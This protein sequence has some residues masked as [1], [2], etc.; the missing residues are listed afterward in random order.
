MLMHFYLV[1]SV[2]LCSLL[3]MGGSV[4][5]R[6]DLNMDN[7]GRPT[8]HNTARVPGFNGQP[9]RVALVFGGYYN[10][11]DV[12]VEDVS[13]DRSQCTGDVYINTPEG[14]INLGSS[15]S[16]SRLPS[17]GIASSDDAEV[18][19]VRLDIG[20]LSELFSRY[21]AISV[22]KNGAENGF[23]FLGESTDNDEFENFCVDGSLMSLPYSCSAETGSCAIQGSDFSFDGRTASPPEHRRPAT[24][25]GRS[26]MFTVPLLM[27]QS[28]NEGLI[29][30]GA[31]PFSPFET[32]FNCSI[33]HNW[34]DIL[35][36]IRVS[37]PS[38]Y[39]LLSA[40]D[41]LAFDSVAG[42]CQP[43]LSNEFRLGMFQPVPQIQPLLL[44]GINIR[45]RANASSIDMCDSVL[46]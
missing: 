3:V 43:K 46:Y 2:P 17:I 26:G 22:I 40:S 23:L 42:S 4:Y 36:Q 18:R 21:D 29:S 20:P 16:E 38:G 10:F 19:H 25:V 27:L 5:L 13:F 14:E 33:D 28:I 31:V 8:I 11:V 15:S 1:A 24:M 6:I 7:F 39:L 44:P 12:A 35:P 34:N 9:P 41:Y 30:A 45:F 37:F 32:Y